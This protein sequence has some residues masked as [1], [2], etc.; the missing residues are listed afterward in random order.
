VVKYGLINDAGFFEW[1][2][3]HGPDVL[4]CGPSLDEAVAVSCRAKAAIVMRD[5]REDGERALL[6]LG[7]TFAHALER[8]VAYDGARLVHGEAV[9]IGLCLAFR[10]SRRLGLCAGQ[11]VERVRAHLAREGLPT[12]LSDVSGGVGDADSL[13]EAMFQDK[14]IVSGELTFILARGIGQ[15][16]IARGVPAADVRLFLMQELIGE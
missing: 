8:A 13:I 2:E 15:S 12:R 7:H 4:A 6:N 9:A 3:R 16:F 5:E 10:F 1:C 14:K 11:D